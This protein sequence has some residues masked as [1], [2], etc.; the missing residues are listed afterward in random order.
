MDLTH[1]KQS[2]R[3]TETPKEMQTDF[4]DGVAGTLILFSIPQN[5][6]LKCPSPTLKDRTR[7]LR[8]RKRD[9]CSRGDTAVRRPVLPK[10]NRNPT[11]LHAMSNSNFSGTWLTSWKLFER[12]KPL[13]RHVTFGK[14][15]QEETR[16][17]NHSKMSVSK[18]QQ[19]ATGG[20]PAPQPGCHWDRASRKLCS[21]RQ[22]WETS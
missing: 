14:E 10:V 4:C 16:S 9:I 8:R 17:G 1:K 5:N 3:V 13:K 2:K 7:Q 19:G 15:R 18:N 20:R 6:N 21:W 12:I 11:E 22:L